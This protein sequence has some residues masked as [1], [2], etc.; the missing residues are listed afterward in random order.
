MRSQHTYRPKNVGFWS[1]RPRLR[2]KPRFLNNLGRPDPNPT[3]NPKIWVDPNQTRPKFKILIDVFKLKTNLNHSI[4]NF[5]IKRR[6][7]KEKNSVLVFAFTAIFN[8]RSWKFMNVHHRSRT[9]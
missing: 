3:Q 2:P 8:E 4:I 7:K 9:I 6:E 5:N 1:D